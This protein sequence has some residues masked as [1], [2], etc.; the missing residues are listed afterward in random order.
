MSVIAV[1]KRGVASAVIPVIAG[2]TMVGAGAALPA[3]QAAETAPAHA[4]APALHGAPRIPLGSTSSIFKNIF[5]EASDGTVF[6]SRG[7]VVYVQKGASAAHVALHPGKAVLA[8]AAS[9][10]DLFVETGLTVTEYSRSNGANLRHWTLT[11]P[12][13]PIT[14]A[15]LLVVGNTLWSWTD[16]GNDSSGFEF[17]KLSRINTTASAVH[18]VDSQVYPADM[19]ANSSGL[20]FEDARGAANT[21]YLVHSTPS[22]TLTARKGSVDAV[23]ALAGGRLDQ[24]SFHNNGHQYI[25]S[26]STSTLVR[27]SSA[28]VSDNDRVIAGTGLGLLVLNQPCAKVTCSSAAVSKLAT[29]GS[30]TGTLTVPHAFYLLTG[31]S[32]AVVEVVGG[33]MYLVRLAS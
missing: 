4:A 12:V 2:L 15:G 21:G 29:N 33:Q 19:A 3:A 11:S 6:Y 16:W 7:S 25:D 31:P 1:W 17:A 24:L 22:G 23:L 5:T 14:I 32:A 30:V 8:L 28:Q 10:S 13:T 18:S 26:Y 20:Y 27:L 9:S